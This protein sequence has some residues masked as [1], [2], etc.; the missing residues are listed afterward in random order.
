MKTIDEIKL[1]WQQHNRDNGLSWNEVA[2]LVNEVSAQ[3]ASE[4]GEE[5][6]TCKELR[7]VCSELAN[8]PTPDA[9]KKM[10][11]FSN[12][13]MDEP[14][15][16]TTPHP[17]PTDF[18]EKVRDINWRASS[19]ESGWFDILV[20]GE[21]AYR[22][23]GIKQRDEFIT[24]LERNSISSLLPDVTEEDISNTFDGMACYTSA[25]GELYLCKE[26]FRLAILD[27]FRKEGR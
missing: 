1:K 7:K 10:S 19:E 11:D 4:Q 22:A 21:L 3:P 14:Y 24:E 2:E 25:E 9:I 6:P 12:F 17:E 8:A 5:C 26:Q 16:A 20:D 18:R 23:K 27:L 13:D 15:M